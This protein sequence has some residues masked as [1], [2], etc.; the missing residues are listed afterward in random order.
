LLGVSLLVGRVRLLWEFR[1]Q[2]ANILGGI[3]GAG[4]LRRLCEL[5]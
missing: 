3:G 1:E 2:E 5:V 4:D